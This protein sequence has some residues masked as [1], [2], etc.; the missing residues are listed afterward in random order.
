[1]DYEVPD[2]PEWRVFFQHFRPLRFN[3]EPEVAW[4]RRWNDPYMERAYINRILR[5]AGLPLYRPES[6]MATP[7]IFGGMTA[8]YIWD[9]V[10]DKCIIVGETECIYPDQFCYAIGRKHAF[11]NALENL[12]K[13]QEMGL[14]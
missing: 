7:S 13:F 10:T 2:H 6:N 5:R 14:R 8:C 4:A 11:E 9:T 3:V 12:K 1:M